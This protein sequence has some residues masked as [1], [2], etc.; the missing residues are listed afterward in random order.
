MSRLGDYEDVASFIAASRRCAIPRKKEEP[1]SEVW[2]TVMGRTLIEGTIPLIAKN[3]GR[4]A[5][6]LERQGQSPDVPRCE[7]CNH[8]HPPAI[9]HNCYVFGCEC[10]H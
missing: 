6:A 1:V 3:L 9:T 2:R 10:K 7:W 4:I 5:D 8:K